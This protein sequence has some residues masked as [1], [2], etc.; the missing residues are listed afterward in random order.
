MNEEERSDLSLGLIFLFSYVF[1]MIAYAI[2]GLYM[3]DFRIKILC[4]VYS[5]FLFILF[6]IRCFKVKKVWGEK[7]D[8]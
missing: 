6:I 1:F 5:L 4:W 8:D 7:Q 2:A 3:N